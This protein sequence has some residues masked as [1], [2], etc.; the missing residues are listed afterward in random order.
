MDHRVVDWA[1]GDMNKVNI[2]PS[3]KESI[4]RKFHREPAKNEQAQAA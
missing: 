2:D 1:N 4:F 3:K